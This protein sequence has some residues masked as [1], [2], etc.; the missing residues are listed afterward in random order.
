M[1]KEEIHLG[2][3]GGDVEDGDLLTV[4]GMGQRLVPITRGEKAVGESVA[5]VPPQGKTCVP[6]REAALKTRV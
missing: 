5:F 6:Q 2:F 4:A 1:L 3:Q